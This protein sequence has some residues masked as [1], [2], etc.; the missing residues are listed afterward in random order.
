[1]NSPQIIIGDYCELAPPKFITVDNIEAYRE[2]HP[3]FQHGK[4]DMQIREA[5]MR[6]WVSHTWRIK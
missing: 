1:M 5:I 2:W 4:S 6:D 3:Y